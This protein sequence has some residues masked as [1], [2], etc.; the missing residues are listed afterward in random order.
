MA[1]RPYLP[2]KQGD[3]LKWHDTLKNGVTATTTGCTAADV[4]M[5]AA[6]NADLKV[7]MTRS[8]ANARALAQRI[9]KRAGYTPSLG[10]TLQL[11][12]VEDSVDMSQQAPVLDTNA[13]S[14]GV[15]EVG[16][17]KTSAEGVH[18]YSQRD[19]DA[20]FVFLASE[21]HS[22]YVDNRA[23]AVAGKP[24]MRQYKAVFF[25]GKSEIGWESDVAQATA[26]P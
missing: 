19:D 15:V 2:K 21:I 13:K 5:L 20:G 18:I 25:L 10:D 17:N 11:E 12:G 9:K 3:Y 8:Q 1:K 16:V 14:G 22:P 26:R 6:D 23:L 4:T 24:E 7:S